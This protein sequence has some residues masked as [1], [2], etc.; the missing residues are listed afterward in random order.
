ME[1]QLF[2]AR[3]QI[4]MYRQKTIVQERLKKEME[5]DLEEMHRYK[6]RDNFFPWKN[7]FDVFFYEANAGV[8]SSQLVYQKLK[9]CETRK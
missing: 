6:P 9:S 3:R 4:D 1:E 5:Y 7:I 8:A 2:D